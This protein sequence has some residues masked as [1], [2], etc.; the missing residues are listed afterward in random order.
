MVIM[1]EAPI[2]AARS[3]QPSAT[4]RDES[5]IV[6]Q[7]SIVSLRHTIKEAKALAPFGHARATDPAEG[8]IEMRR[9]PASKISSVL[10]A[11]TAVVMLLGPAIGQQPRPDRAARGR[12]RDQGG[13]PLKK[14]RPDAADPLARAVGNPAHPV[15][16][17]FHYVFRIRSFDG[18][19]LAASYYPSKLGNTAPVVML[20]HEIGRSRKDFDEPVL[21]LK[22]QGLAEHLQSLGYAVLS[23]DMRGQGQN[24]RRVITAAE[25]PQL[26]EDI[27]AG[28]FFLVDRHNRGDLN[29]AKLGIIALGD[30][31]NLVAAWAAQPGAAVTTEGRTSDLNALVLISPMPEGFGYVLGQALSSLATR[32]P[33]LIMAGERDNPSKDAAQ[34]VKNL[35]TRGRLNKVELFPS[36]FH[37]YKLLRLE[38]KLTTTLFHFLETALKN[39]PVDWEPQY[40]LTPIMLADNPQTVLNSRPAD[41]TKNQPNAKDAEVPAAKKAAVANNRKGANAENPKQ[42]QDQN[43]P[44]PAK[45]D[46]PE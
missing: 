18:A 37:G 35:V 14:A 6:L 8:A 15:P 34:S 16:G 41:R 24:P 9:D 12:V 27:Q 13:T 3:K 4:R 5:L 2:F 36:T 1:T 10:T 11:A 20:V 19:P 22:G 26:I 30:G 29:L 21:E 42:A 44:A 7:L 31:S 38:P 28:Y 45:A 39:R 25:R 33:L 17:T 43:A 40:N 23:M 32:V 46:G